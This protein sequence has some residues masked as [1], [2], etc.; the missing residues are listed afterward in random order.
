MSREVHAGF[1][2]QP[3]GKFPGLTRLL[4]GFIGP[5]DEAATVK[6]KVASYL[7]DSL[8]LELNEEKTLVTH[9]RNER[10]RF[11]GYE[12]HSLHEDSKQ[13]R[14][15][16]RCINGSIGFRVPARVV[17]DKCAQ[18]SVR[19][20]ATHLAGLTEDDAYRI[21]NRYQDEYRGTVLYYRMAYNL[22]ASLSRLRYVM[23]TSLVKTLARK[24]RTSRREIVRRYGTRVKTREGSYQA[25]QVEVKRPPPQKPLIA[26]FG[27][28][29]LQWNSQG[30]ARDDTKRPKRDGERSELVKRLL[31]QECELCGAK[32]KIQIHHLR[33]PADLKTPDGAKPPAWKVRMAA[34]R[35]K[36]LAVRRGC[37][38]RIHQGKY[39][40]ENL[41]RKS[42][43][44]AT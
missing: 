26:R 36:T 32:E 35:R 4:L 21:I 33:G 9:A 39:D 22:A 8:K 11:L 40:G 5:K 37:H 44:R 6:Q 30:P 7:R 16:T 20:K 18:Y 1:C 24:F 17:Q 25:F 15:G 27:G 43:R 34:R 38:V 31:A 19:G 28:I 29:S 42:C 10:A 13:S 41:R 12:V 23:A 2:E 14:H 3:K